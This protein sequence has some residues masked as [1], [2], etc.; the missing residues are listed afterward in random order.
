MCEIE[1]YR[2]K[3]AHAKVLGSKGTVSRKGRKRKSAQAVVVKSPKGQAGHGIHV[4]S[5]GL[6]GRV[7]GAADGINQAGGPSMMPF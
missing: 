2:Q 4:G 7:T 5:S 3:R 1:L 6:D